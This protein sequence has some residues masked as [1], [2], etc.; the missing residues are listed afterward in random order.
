MRDGRNVLEAV[1]GKPVG[2]TREFAAALRSGDPALAERV[3]ESLRRL[4]ILAEVSDTVTEQLTLDHQLPRMITLI[5]EVFDA[6]RATLFLN[7]PDAGELFSRVASGEGVREI[8]IPSSAGIAGAVFQSGEPVVIDD[9]Y[10]DR[11]FNPEVDR[12]TGYVTRNMLCVPLRNREG[13]PNGVTQVL[14]KRKGAFTE[15]D[16][17]LL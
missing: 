9:V 15:D 11:R 1:I 13:K 3:V 4:S 12:Q 2:E 14:N 17:A 5:C 8:R 16:E 10:K 6:E 7:D